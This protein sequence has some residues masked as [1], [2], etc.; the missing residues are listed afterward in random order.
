MLTYPQLILI[1]NIK[2]QLLMLKITLKSILATVISLGLL[3]SCAYKKDGC[4]ANCSSAKGN[5]KEENKL[6]PKDAKAEAKA[7]DKTTEKKA[8]KKV[9]KAKVVKTEASA[10][11]TAEKTEEKPAKK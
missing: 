7:E 1:K 8:K 9:K 11:K 2:Y 10:E 5:Y 6:A 3:A 4:G